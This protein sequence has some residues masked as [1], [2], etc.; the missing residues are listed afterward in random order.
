MAW[1]HGSI[2]KSRTGWGIAEAIDL[3]I[4]DIYRLLAKEAT[5]EARW[6]RAI[7]LYLTCSPNPVDR[8][9]FEG[10]LLDPH[11]TPHD[12]N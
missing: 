11:A 5:K 6:R 8:H 7:R 12:G 2:R 3:A 9:R 4:P 10:K 1:A